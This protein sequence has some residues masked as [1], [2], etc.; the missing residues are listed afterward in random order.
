MNISNHT[1]LEKNPEIVLTVSY[2][3][4]EVAISQFKGGEC[5][6]I[7]KSIKQSYVSK[8]YFER[9]KRNCY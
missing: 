9:E 7:H 8:H 5:A 6:K 2:I 4:V 3:N 1:L